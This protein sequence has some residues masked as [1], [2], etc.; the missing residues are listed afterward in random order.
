[1]DGWMLL[2]RRGGV[3]VFFFFWGGG[4]FWEVVGMVCGFFFGREVKYNIK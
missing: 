1:M 3:P 2:Q 4:R